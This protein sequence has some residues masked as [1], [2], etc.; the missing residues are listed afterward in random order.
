MTRLTRRREDGEGYVVDDAH[1]SH[2]AGGYSG[3]AIQRLAQF[4]NAYEELVAGQARI[5]EELERLRSEGKKNTVRF[6]ELL[7]E[8]LLNSRIIGL[9]ERRGLT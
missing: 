5:A 3:E 7:G 1:I 2:D 9:F 6:R 8:K 4:E